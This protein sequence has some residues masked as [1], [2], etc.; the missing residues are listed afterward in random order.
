MRRLPRPTLARAGLL[1]I[2]LCLA[3][4]AFSAPADAGLLADLSFDRREAW[5]APVQYSARVMGLGLAGL[6]AFDLHDSDPSFENFASALA[7]PAPRPDDDGPVFNYVL[8]PLWG[9]ETYL[10]ARAAD[11]SPADSFAFSMG[12]SV[13]WEYLIESWTEHPSSQDL[14]FTTGLG[15]VLGEARYRLLQ[16]ADTRRQKL[17]DP[18]HTALQ[19]VNIETTLL[20]EDEAATPH[21]KV[22]WPI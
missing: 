4:G 10:R 17:L 8:H 19:H 6:V 16:T 14:M 9:S 15:W 1:G 22:R 18:L 11:F 3:L 21:L 20:S 12:A 7:S 13:T 2:V 5:E